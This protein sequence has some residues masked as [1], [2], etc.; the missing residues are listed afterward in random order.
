M[1]AG[2]G[3]EILYGN[4][5]AC[6]RLGQLSESRMALLKGTSL[7]AQPPVGAALMM[8][9]ARDA[10]HNAASC[11]DLQTPALTQLHGARYPA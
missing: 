3:H 8:R 9:A 10:F 4:L 2:D 11:C 6:A 1:T 7:L 5:A